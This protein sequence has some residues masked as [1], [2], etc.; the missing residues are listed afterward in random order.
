MSVRRAALWDQSN[1]PPFWIMM[2]FHR[3]GAW[4][5]VILSYLP[6]APRRLAE[7]VTVSPGGDGHGD[8]L[9]LVLGGV[10]AGLPAGDNVQ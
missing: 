5:P 10:M 1:A 2:S 9:R 7:V 6:A 4:S 3:T 8:G